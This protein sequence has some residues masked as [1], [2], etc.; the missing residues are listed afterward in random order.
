MISV[1]DQ[2]EECCGCTACEYIC[3]TNAIKMVLDEEGFLYPK[4]DQELCIDCGKCRKSCAFQNGFNKNSNLDIPEVYGIKHIDDDVRNNSSSGGAFT[5]VSDYIFSKKGIVCGVGFNEK[6]EVIHKFANNKYE[7]NLLRGSKY[8]QSE[9]KDIFPE[10][11]KMLLDNREVLFSG[12]PCQVVGLK[13]YLDLLK[14]DTQNLL[15]IDIICHGTPSPMLWK[16]YLNFLEKKKGKKVSEYNFRSKIKGWHEHTES[17]RYS[18]NTSDYK[19]RELQIFRNIFY[20]HN[21]LRPSCHNCKY[22]NYIRP[23]DITIADFRGIEKINKN[24][25]DNKGISLVLIN[26]DNGKFLFENI[27]GQFECYISNTS[28][29]V[30]RNLV[31][32]TPISKN[33]EK[34]WFDYHNYGFE[35]IAKKYAGYNLKSIV[36]KMVK[37]ILEKI[38][39]MRLF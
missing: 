18:D 14:C 17:V 6:M 1:Y 21:A 24:F 9:L 28:D 22:T 34:F 26:T 5:G 12:T 35:F 10:I 23:S 4:I 2:K 25:D 7:R 29:C 13:N 16:Q 31:R 38:G 19:S 8:V 30:Q 36:K 33:R 27:K 39:L 37:V 15:T 20:S 32:P 3:P 11:K